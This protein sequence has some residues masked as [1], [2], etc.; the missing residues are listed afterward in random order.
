MHTQP[1]RTNT[2]WIVLGVAFVCAGAAV[3][4]GAVV[5]PPDRVAR[6]SYVEG[7]VSLAPAAAEQWVDAELN[8]PLTSGDRV[9]VDAGSRAELQIDTATI[10]LDEN[11][12]LSFVALDDGAIRMRLTDG[13]IVVHVRS[14][15]AHGIHHRRNEQRNRHAATSR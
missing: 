2:L 14:L 8:R 15:A 3:A 13:A 10:H 1:L 9:W 12:S 11:T 6:L 5:D 4:Q 7:A